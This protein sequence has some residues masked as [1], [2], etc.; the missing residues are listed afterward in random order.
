MKADGIPALIARAERDRRMPA[1][2]VIASDE[3]LLSQEAADALRATARSLGYSEREVL[4]TDARFDWSKLAQASQGLSLFA[5]R[6]ILEI[7]LPT[8]K[9]GVAG[10]AALEALAQH[11]NEDTFTLVLLPWLDGRAR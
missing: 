2:V 10:A 1:L 4:Q 6:R 3:P 8:G 5:E 7:R 11:L 9:P